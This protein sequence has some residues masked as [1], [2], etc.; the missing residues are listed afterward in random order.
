MVLAT[1]FSLLNNDNQ[2]T[3][4]QK[5]KNTFFWDG[6]LVKHTL[7]P[8]S[9]FKVCLLLIFSLDFFVDTCFPSSVRD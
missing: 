4:I 2:N 7:K 8:T 9:D 5:E 6:H 1:A 3:Y